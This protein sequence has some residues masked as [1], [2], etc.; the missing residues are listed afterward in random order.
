MMT[1]YA[2]YEKTMLE[3]L[4][5]WAD[6]HHRGELDGG[7]RQGRP[8]VL[9]SRFALRDVLIPPGG[10]AANDIRTAIPNISSIGGSA[11]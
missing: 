4:W 11:A 8:P 3:S 6:R 10:A 7:K 9:A 2:D 5:I 1:T